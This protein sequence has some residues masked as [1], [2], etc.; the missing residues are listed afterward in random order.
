MALEKK[1]TLFYKASVYYENLFQ[2]NGRG[3]SWSN[4]VVASHGQF[5]VAGHGIGHI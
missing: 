4:F 2:S 3:G 5:F 1:R